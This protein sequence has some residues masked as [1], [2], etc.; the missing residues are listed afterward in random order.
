[1]SHETVSEHNGW[2]ISF[3]KNV[4]MYCHA[5]AA[6]KGNQSFQISCE[7]AP[8][9]EGLVVMWPY[10]LGLSGP[11]YSDLVA[12]LHDWARA[13]GLRYRIYVAQNRF[14]PAVPNGDSPHKTTC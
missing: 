4:H 5:L 11:V 2:A 7:D 12:A 14:E 1:M 6:S 10:A 13:G 9:G 3:E 8:L